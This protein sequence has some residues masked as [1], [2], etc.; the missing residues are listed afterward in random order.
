MLRERTSVTKQ[1][2]N[3]T[4]SSVK[5][6]LGFWSLTSIGIGG[7]VGGGL[8][9]VLGLTAILAKGA[10]P[11]AFIMAGT[12]AFLTSYSYAKLSVAYPSQGGTV[13]FLNHA[14]GPGLFSGG[15][16]ILL[17]LSYVIIIALY[18]VGLANYAMSLF[19]HADP[20]WK[21]IILSSVVIFLT[22]LNMISPSL[23]IK[24]E[25]FFNVFKLVILAGFIIAG[26]WT[27]DLNRLEPKAWGTFPQI[28]AGG[29]IIFLS[30]EGFELIA[31]ASLATK[32][33]EKNLPKAFYT[34]VLFVIG[35]YLLISIVAIGNLPILQF[36]Q[37]RDYALAQSALPFFGNGG[38]ILVSVA[39]IIASASAINAAL[40]GSAKVTFIVAKDGQL[41]TFLDRM[42]VGKPIAGLLLLAALA[43]I[44]GNFFNIESISMMASAGFLFIFAAVN[45]ANFKLAKETHSNRFISA[46]AFASC[47]IATLSIIH[48]KWTTD[49]IKILALVALISFSF[50]IELIYRNATGRKI[51]NFLHVKFKP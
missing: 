32:K 4:N 9:A 15:L 6:T 24:S 14:F 28:L 8:F 5:P 27:V 33:P 26:I 46:M 40:Y 42:V 45:A 34:S 18:A 7:M 11:L 2:M 49:P 3:N 44:V 21:N 41:P 17:C 25:L 19:P 35:L 10:T 23:V 47:V 1:I 36:V 12:V 16:N 48:Y 50:L 39:A 51:Q 37:A 20:I 30:Y 13:V 31:N 29:M 43:L 38:F 22:L